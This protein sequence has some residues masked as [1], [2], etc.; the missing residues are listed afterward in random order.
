MTLSPKRSRRTYSNPT[1]LSYAACAPSNPDE[2]G[3]SSAHHGAISPQVRDLC[4]P[5]PEKEGGGG[6]QK[7]QSS[8]ASVGDKFVKSLRDL[9]TELQSS[10]AWFVRC[11]KSNP[12]LKPLL[13]NGEVSA[14][15]GTRSASED[16]LI[17]SL[18]R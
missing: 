6:K 3:A 17:A 8:F 2:E 14:P 18:I 10:Q 9:M 5:E 15:V 4:K 7:A 16:L 11:I 1:S 13:M 12:Q